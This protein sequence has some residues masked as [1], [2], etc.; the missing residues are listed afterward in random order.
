A[1]QEQARLEKDR[2][3]Q[4]RQEQARRQQELCEQSGTPTFESHDVPEADDS[5]EP[6][7]APTSAV[8]DFEPYQTWLREEELY[9]PLEA[10]HGICR[11]KRLANFL[12]RHDYPIDD[13]YSL[14]LRHMKRLVKRLKEDANF[15]AFNRRENGN[16][17]EALR[18]FCVYAK[19]VNE[20]RAKA[21]ATRPTL[22]DVSATAIIG[23]NTGP[24]ASQ[25][26]TSNRL[27]DFARPLD[28]S[29][30]KPTRL[31]VF[32][33]EIRVATWRD[34]YLNVVEEVWRQSGLSARK[35]VASLEGV[36][37][38]KPISRPGEQRSWENYTLVLDGAYLIKTHGSANDLLRRI[39]KLLRTTDTP[40][41]RVLIEYAPSGSDLPAS[42]CAKKV[43]V[44]RS[45]G[46]RILDFADLTQTIEG[47]PVRLVVFGQE[48]LVKNWRGVYRHVIEAF[49]RHSSKS[50]E[51]F[52]AT[53]ENAQ[54]FVPIDHPEGKRFWA[55]YVLALDDAY[56][57]NIH[58][59]AEALHNRLRRLLQVTGTP[60]GQ[61]FV[62]YAPGVRKRKRRKTG[63]TPEGKSER[64]AAFPQEL[65]QRAEEIL[66]LRFPNGYRADAIGEG[67]F[68]EE[69]RNLFHADL[70]GEIAPTALVKAVA[71]CHNEQS[72]YRFSDQAL[73]TLREL[74]NA[75]FE[76]GNHVISPNAFYDKK[77]ALLDGLNLTNATLTRKALR[78]AMPQLQYDQH[79]FLPADCD[80]SPEEQLQRDA[81]GVIGEEYSCP[82]AQM[83]ERLSFSDPTR[84]SV[85]MRRCDLFVIEADKTVYQVAKL[86]IDPDDLKAT[87]AAIEEKLRKFGVAAKDDIVVARSIGINGFTSEPA[88][89]EALFKQALTREYVLSNDQIDRRGQAPAPSSGGSQR[90]TVLIE[91][92]RKR[93]TLELAELEALEIERFNSVKLSLSVA[94]SQMIRANAT[95]FVARDAFNVDVAETDRAISMFLKS[96]VMPLMDVTSFNCFYSFVPNYP[97]NH[98]LL[99]GYC[100]HKSKRYDFMG[101]HF[102]NRV[103]GA[104]YPKE[105]A[106]KSYN[107]ILATIAFEKK[108]PT[109]AK[110]LLDFLLE[111]GLI[112]RRNF[113]VDDV[114]ALVQSLRYKQGN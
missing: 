113:H 7:P 34:V 100:A 11:V 17:K 62:E 15:K 65:R 89:R 14:N 42:S 71:H 33:K 108:A 12:L 23:N 5:A 103:I 106:F 109:S 112:A 81:L 43:A 31:V 39:R 73:Q 91:Y 13:L 56:F 60:R 98:F 76:R 87:R 24:S 58:F 67:Q 70:P 57:M 114:I 55:R 80:L 54:D 6:T 40:Y 93:Q 101:F 79:A 44:K 68:R 46:N 75:A 86:H 49:Y 66:L 61:V 104:I 28:A 94:C 22:A 2:I 32:G 96:G 35:F 110:E 18:L 21:P 64:D 88:M 9:E 95:D 38:F 20:S 16:I 84:L 45:P 53:L 8:F 63:V 83:K 51:E 27:V 52:I 72:Y 59:S 19:A 4:A 3:E 99:A 47:K 29:S 77:G 50:P 82:L 36:L 1:R 26:S 90:K 74:V 48:L 25:S 92:C 78:I 37:T 30:S 41:D 107:E 10:Y 97:W 85:A 111:N 69:Y 102:Q 105:H